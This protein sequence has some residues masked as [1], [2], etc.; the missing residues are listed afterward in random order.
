[1]KTDKS[2]TR[3][4]GI[5]VYVANLESKP[6]ANYRNSQ[7]SSYPKEGGVVC[8][9]VRKIEGQEMSDKLLFISQGEVYDSLTIVSTAADI[10]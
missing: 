6:R 1:M 7:D 5:A 10:W 8:N 4:L 3:C 2:K 9:V